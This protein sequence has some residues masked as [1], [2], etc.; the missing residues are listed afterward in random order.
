MK[1]KLTPLQEVRTQDAELQAAWEK[2][3][4]GRREAR[5]KSREDARETLRAF[6]DPD[7]SL[8]ERLEILK[9]LPSWP[10][11]V[12]GLYEAERAIAEQRKKETPPLKGSADDVEPSEDAYEKVGEAVGLGQHRIKALCNEG[13]QHLREG[14]P[15]KPQI[16]VEEF[17]RCLRPL[18]RE[19]AISLQKEFLEDLAKRD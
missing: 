16:S 6:T 12:L 15:S 19:A 8:D 11:I 10:R 13:R 14:Q 9:G 17:K 4:A 3:N 2:W 7:L 1:K 18:S 5:E